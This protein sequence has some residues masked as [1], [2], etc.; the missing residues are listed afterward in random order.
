M[1][2]TRKKIIFAS[3]LLL[4]STLIITPSL[5]V[6]AANPTAILLDTM[7]YDAT[8]DRVIMFGGFIGGWSTRPQ[9]GFSFETWTYNFNENYWEKVTVDQVP[10]QAVTSIVYDSESDKTILFGG[11]Y[12][13]ANPR[14]DETWVF[15][16]NENTWTNM[17]PETSPYKRQNHKMVYNSESD[18]V[19]LFGGSTIGYYIENEF[20]WLNDT[21]AYDFNSNTW[22]SQNPAIAPE[23]RSNF[24]FAYDSESDKCILFGGTVNNTGNGWTDNGETW[25]YDYNTNT[26]EDMNVSSGPTRREFHTMAYDSES[27]RII[28]LGGSSTTDSG[29][30]SETWAYDYNSN[31]WT[32]SSSTFRPYRT[33]HSMTYDAESDRIIVFGGAPSGSLETADTYTWIYDYNSDT[34]VKMEINTKESPISIYP[35]TISLSLLAVM[36]YLYKRKK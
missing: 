18:V 17:N 32:E 21:W 35:V 29:A 12:N 13:E 23:G 10:G 34:W 5:L 26:W 30:G 3:S 16:A 1:K 14:K 4:I 31:T 9:V 33:F 36:I 6:N 22:T 19:I 11:K 27:D 20:L 7:C 15:D 28:L 8:A 25:A 24:A 2:K